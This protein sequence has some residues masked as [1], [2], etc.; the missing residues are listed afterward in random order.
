MGNY[1]EKSYTPTLF[2]AGVFRLVKF[3]FTEVDGHRRYLD[4][5]LL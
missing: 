1:V 5:R 4:V 2:E 3:H